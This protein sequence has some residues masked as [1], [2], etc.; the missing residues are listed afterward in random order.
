MSALL[1]GAARLDIELGDS[2]R[3]GVDQLG[4]AL[5]DG[6]Q[7]VNLTRIT[8]PAEIETRHFLDSL[9]AALPL[10]DRLRQGEP[11]R[12]VDVGS[13]GG[14]PGLP[15]KIAFPQLRV[16]LVESVGKKAAFLRETVEQLGLRDVQGIAE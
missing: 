12:L 13:G 3:A 6:N 11:L 15:L 10:L 4:A 9:S 14:M 7:R 8:D 1:D 16:T 2:K 5:R